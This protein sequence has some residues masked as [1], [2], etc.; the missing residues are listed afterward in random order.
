MARSLSTR[1][2]FAVSYLVLG[3]VVGVGIGSFFVLL[4]RD[5]PPPPPAWSSWRPTAADTNTRMLE[6]ANHTPRG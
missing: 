6:I 1:G 5:P 2:R 4:R 3:A